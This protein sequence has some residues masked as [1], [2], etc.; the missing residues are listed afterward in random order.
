M[1][2]LKHRHDQM[3]RGNVP[4]DQLAT[5]TPTEGFVPTVQGDGSVAWESPT[6]AIALNDLTDVDTASPP[7][8]DGQVLTWVTGDSSWEPTDPSVA[9]IDD[10]TDVD[11]TSVPPTDGQVLTWVDGDSQW[12]PRDAGAGDVTTTP[13]ADQI[14][15]AQSDAILP[16][17]VKG[18]AS[19]VANLFEARTSADEQVF[20]LDPTGRV[21]ERQLGTSSSEAV[22]LER[23]AADSSPVEIYVRRSR[24][25]TVAHTI[26]ADSDEILA[27]IFQGSNGSAWRTA[28]R[29]AVSV[30]GTPGS[31]NDMPGK[32]TLA[33]TPD[34]SATS[35][36][37][38]DI[39]S[40]G[41]ISLMFGLRLPG[42]ITPTSL[43]STTDDYAPTDGTGAFVWRLGSASGDATLRGIVA[44]ADGV[45]HLIVNSLTVGNL[46]FENRNVG[47]STTVNT[48]ICPG[49]ADYTLTPGSSALIWYDGTSDRWR[50]IGT[51]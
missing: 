22:A 28:A 20:W 29:I 25:N 50:V 13:S 43:G 24:S 44:E 49:E 7:P 18:A 37:R 30:N 41:L 21:V 47:D 46:I 5:G 34:G 40:T 26:V 32:I 2:F 17:A 16:L 3:H 51:A 33:T 48:F 12:E 31:G 36:P 35:V 15:E 8:S 38:L 6:P 45:M 19:Q 9:V 14:I 4:S 39:D 42:T 11:T 1:A 23:Y 27:L 10:L